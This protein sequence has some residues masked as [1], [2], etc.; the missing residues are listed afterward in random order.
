MRININN[1]EQYFLDYVEGRLGQDEIRDLEV[2]MELHPELAR[3]LNDYEK[4]PIGPDLNIQYPKKDSIRKKNQPTESIHH[5]NIESWIISAVERELTPDEMIELEHFISQNPAYDYDLKTYKKTI[6]QPQTEIVFPDKRS[7]K[8]SPLIIFKKATVISIVSVAA[9]ILLMISIRI[10]LVQSDKQINPVPVNPD[11]AINTELSQ[12]RINELSPSVSTYGVSRQPEENSIVKPKI[13]LAGNPQVDRSKDQISFR[14]ERKNAQVFAPL[15]E[16]E[17][18]RINYSSFT[19]DI[20]GSKIE[21]QP[22]TFK[23][24]GRVLAGLFRQA[25]DVVS[26]KT[27]VDHIVKPNWD[28]WS[29]ADAGVRSFNF[30]TDREIEMTLNR[31][32]NGSF[33]SYSFVEDNN[34]IFTKPINNN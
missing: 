25:K 14:L 1:Y 22:G 10:L 28:F 24:I 3:L 29:A 5:D 2:F 11:V 32:K 16:N 17:I 4:M 8:K 15:I 31:D 34:V 9:T 21:K 12:D 33:N 7:L 26:D 13:I 6:I 27:G 23:V 30:L 19:A 18:G 20:P